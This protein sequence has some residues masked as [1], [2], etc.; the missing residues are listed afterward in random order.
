MW[1]NNGMFDSTEQTS[2][3]PVT[4]KETPGKYRILVNGK[5]IGSP[6]H[7]DVSQDSLRTIPDGAVVCDGVGGSQGGEVASRLT[8]DIFATALGRAAKTPEAIKKAM[9]YAAVEAKKQIIKARQNQGLRGADTTVVSAIVLP[10][11]KPDEFEV[12][13]GNIGDSQAYVLRLDGTLE[14]ISQ[15]HSMVEA[16]VGA[17]HIAKEEA[18]TR[19]DRNVIYRAVGS[20]PEGNKIDTYSVR[21]RRG[22]AV[23]LLSD[24][25]TDNVPERLGDVDS[26]VDWKTV[27]TQEEKTIFDKLGLQISRT[28]EVSEESAFVKDK[29]SNERLPLPA[30]QGLI[31]D[32]IS[33]TKHQDLRGSA[34]NVCERV[35]QLMYADTAFA[36]PDDISCAIIM[37]T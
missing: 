37:P 9:Q 4:A 33:R 36:K 25:V 23:V 30:L 18:F 2:S 13:C 7:P 10:T 11:D 27:K 22:E 28:G 24:G 14:R 20:E 16:Q 3:S 31:G 8:A 35:L 21:I 12:I 15:P 32:A 5:V 6:D 19:V 29:R 1:L 17:G 26:L 34:E